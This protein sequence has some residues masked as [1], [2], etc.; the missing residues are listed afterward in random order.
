MTRRSRIRQVALVAGAGAALLT[1]FLFYVWG[2]VQIV[3][4]GY[5]IE[6]TADRLHRLEQENRALRLDKARLESL[7]RIEERARKLGLVALPPARLV[8][9]SDHRET[10]PT[11]P[12]LPTPTPPPGGA[13]P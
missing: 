8:R 4:S 5:R 2:N 12:A 7:A 11:A 10:A 13:R 3:S 9:L 6:E 1:P